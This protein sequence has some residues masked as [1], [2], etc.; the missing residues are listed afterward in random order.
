MRLGHIRYSTRPSARRQGL[1]SWA[2]REMLQIATQTGLTRVLLV[3]E[4]DNNPSA[5]MIERRGGV[6]ETTDASG[7]HRYWIKL[8]QPSNSVA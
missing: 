3:C 2:L 8:D 7:E 4:I 5:S 1:A 6:A